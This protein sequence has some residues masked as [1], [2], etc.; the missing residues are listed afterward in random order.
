MNATAHL[1]EPPITP[2]YLQLAP[3]DPIE[4]GSVNVELPGINGGPSLQ[5]TALFVE[6]F[7]QGASLEVIVPLPESPNFVAGFSDAHVRMRQQ[8]TK[9]HLPDYGTSIGAICTHSSIERVVYHPD[10]SPIQIRPASTEITNVIFHLFNWPAIR[11]PENYVLLTGTPP[12]QGARGCGRFRLEV[13]DWIITVAEFRESDEVIKRLEQDGGYAI[14][15]VGNIERLNGQQFS[16]EQLNNLLACLGYFFSFVLGRW[17]MPSLAV[18]VD[19]S[20]NRVYEH[21][22]LGQTTAGHWSGGNSL[23][24]RQHAELLPSL[25][26]GFWRLWHDLIW[27]RP[28]TEAIYWYLGA[29]N[30]GSGVN[31]DSGL[32]FTQAALELL[33]WTYCVLDKKTAS[34]TSFE[35]RLTAAQKLSLLTSAL[36]I[37]NGIPTSMKVLNNT[38]GSKWTDSM[39]VITDLRN[40]LVHPKSRIPPSPGTYFEAWQLSLWYIDLILLRLCD[41]NEKYSNRLAA[42]WAGQVED[43]PWK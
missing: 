2:L 30:V 1:D 43:V 3:N 41:Y 36:N 39:H 25:F 11:G 34:K 40:G 15:H 10:Q 29:N 14:T 4:Y 12:L 13:D 17:S 7:S 16:T 28:L 23:F 22:G 24:D 18:G 5:S 26:P 33:S 35:K 20:G 32:L 8:K 38:P 21:W 37:P 42:R 27:H 19:A 31:V 9:L 6:R